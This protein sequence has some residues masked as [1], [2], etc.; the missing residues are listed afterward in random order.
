MESIKLTDQGAIA[1]LI[2]DQP[3]SKV[4][5]LSRSLWAELAEAVRELGQRPDC[6][7]LVIASAKPGIFI[8][9]ADLK[10]LSNV[11][12]PDHAP[13]QEF[14]NQGLAVL[15]ALEQLPFPT[16]ACIDGAALG[17]G[18]EVALACDYRLASADPKTKLGLPEITLGLIPGWG[19]TQRLPRL[20]GALE[21]WEVLR[22]NQA[23]DANT[24]LK[25]G[26]VAKVVPSSKL[27]DEA[28]LLLNQSF[29]NGSWQKVRLAKMG[30]LVT[31]PIPVWNEVLPEDSVR[32]AVFALADVIDRGLPRQL[33]DAIPLETSAFMRLAAS[34]ESRE[35]ITQFFASRRK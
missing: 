12:N 35:L 1:Q 22:H 32:A 29:S 28:I 17:G 9:G 18:L 4:N 33:Y 34:P 31:E 2:V 30:P 3:N 13:T 16:A 14:M 15:R 21:S 10:E 20:I 11:P 25:K 5:V 23:L 7:G 27:L 19:G 6:R 26:L 8:A 24:A